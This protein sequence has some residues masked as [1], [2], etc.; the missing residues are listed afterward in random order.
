MLPGQ[1]TNSPIAPQSIAHKFRLWIIGAL[2]EF[3]LY[4][5]DTLMETS[6]A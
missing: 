5:R 2:S 3:S 4:T 6:Y 1:T